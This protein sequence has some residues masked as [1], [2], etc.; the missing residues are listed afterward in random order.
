MK[1]LVI[2][3]GG[4]GAP[5][6]FYMTKAQKDVTLIARGKAYEKIKEDGLTV[7]YADNASETVKVKVSK[8]EEYTGTPDVIFVCV[9]AYSIDEIVP[10]LKRIVKPETVVIPLLNIFTTGEY[11]AQKLPLNLVT[12]GCIY[13][14]ANIKVPGVISMHGKIFRVVFGTRDNADRCATLE[15]A[16]KDLKE[17]D[18]TGI[19]SDNIKR[20]ALR[21]FS[22]VSAAAACGLYY[23]SLADRMQNDGKERRLF[24]SLIEE[25]TALSNAMGI[26][27]EEN[28]VKVNLA[29]LDKLAP[30]AGTSMQRDIEKGGRSEIDGLIHE[31]VR[32][33]EKYGIELKN[34]KMISQ[35]FSHLH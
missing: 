11:L 5:I 16:E 35:K 32:L 26:D 12:D 24:S 6:A 8:E 21:K 1:Y 30:T 4:T 33:S 17:S 9:K 14:S 20:D 18:I 34:Y 10:F 28:M 3:A 2:G 22:Y 19:L 29:I 7:E 27:L 31:V 23:D 13:I 15:T 25:I